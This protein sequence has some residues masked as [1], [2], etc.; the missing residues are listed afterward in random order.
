[1][2]LLHLA[3]QAAFPLN[4]S[5]HLVKETKH[6]RQISSYD[7]HYLVLEDLPRLRSVVA[8]TNIV[9][10]VLMTVFNGALASFAI[11]LAGSFA[12][13]HAINTARKTERNDESVRCYCD[14]V[15]T[16]SFILRASSFDRRRHGSAS[17]GGESEN[18]QQLHY[19]DVEDLKLRV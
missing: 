2:P 1:M 8:D 9:L 11:L 12:V 16:G 4:M 14:L 5:A 13:E 7:A 15:E 19:G 3:W 6:I 18:R 17:D 10:I